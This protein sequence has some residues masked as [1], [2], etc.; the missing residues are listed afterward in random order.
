MKAWSKR[1][2]EEANLLNPA[3]L[4]T[5]VSAAICGYEAETDTGMPLPV[6]H[7]IAPIALRK[8]T[9]ERLPRSV[10]SSVAIWLQKNAEYRLLFAERI[11]ALKPYL[12]EALVFGFQQRLFAVSSDG[13]ISANTEMKTI[14]KQLRSLNGDAKECVKKAVFLGKWFASTGSPQT[15][16]ALWGIR[17]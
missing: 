1:P 15:L 8:S 10:R 5:T 11:V 13:N 2:V 14:D 6:V 16:M 4:A 12:N 17:P 7:M 9:R 3:F